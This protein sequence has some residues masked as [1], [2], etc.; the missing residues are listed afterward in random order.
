MTEPTD[1][2]VTHAYSRQAVEEYLQAVEAQRRVLEEA[3]GEARARTARATQ[4]EKRILDLELRV[5]QLVVEAH[6]Q[7]EKRPDESAVF[8]D[9]SAV[10]S[11]PP[12]PL[13]EVEDPDDSAPVP[14]QGLKPPP[15][16]PPPPAG[17]ESNSG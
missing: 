6:V 15:P 7:S 10:S 14:F 1:L 3:I 4:V 11:P 17:W 2:E 12:A 16:P 5:G 13:R 9:A 8:T